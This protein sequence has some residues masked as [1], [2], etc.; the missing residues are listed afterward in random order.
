MKWKKM[1]EKKDKTGREIGEK[2]KGKKGYKE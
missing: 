2:F 1:K